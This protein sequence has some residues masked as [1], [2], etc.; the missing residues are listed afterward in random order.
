M[1]WIFWDLAGPFALRA[2]H[3]P[4]SQTLIEQGR[5]ALQTQNIVTAV[6]VSIRGFDTLGEVVVLFIAAIAV[7]FLMRHR[8]RR[9]TA[10][11]LS[12]ASE[13][14][15][16]CAGIMT[17]MVMVL[18]IYVFTHGHLTP[19]GGFQGGVIVATAVI[20]L[21]LSGRISGL[22]HT[23]LRLTESLSGAG[24]VALALFGLALAGSFLDPRFLPLGSFGALLS[25]GAIPLIYIFLGIKV[26]AE[27][28]GIVTALKRGER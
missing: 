3:T 22:N 12:P 18:G 14:V 17:P 9:T 24:Y 16:T 21:I 28:I 10:S 20:L 27:L 26:G 5:D 6:V 8:E 4:L 1:G 19:G 25:A 23:V 7:G 11:S 13:I 2:G 15:T